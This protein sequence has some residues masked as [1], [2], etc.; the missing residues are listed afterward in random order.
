[1]A[2]TVY[3]NNQAY[4]QLGLLTLVLNTL[5]NFLLFNTQ[6]TTLSLI[7]YKC[8]I[9]SHQMQYTFNSKPDFN[10]ILKINFMRYTKTLNV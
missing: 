7:A 10:Y 3:K 1:M 6:L 5:I 8:C 4:Y 2:I 9:I